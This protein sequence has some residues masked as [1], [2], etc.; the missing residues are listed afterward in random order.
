MDNLYASVAKVLELT[1]SKKSSLRTAVYNHK[2]KNKKQLLRLS[3]ETLKYRAYLTKIL[4]CQ[5]VMRHIIKCDKLNNQKEL[6]LILLYELV[7]GKGVSL[8]DK[9]IKR[10]VLGAKKDILTEHQALMDDGIDPES[11]AKT[12][13]IVLPRYGRVNTLKAGMDEV[14]SALQEEGYEFLDNSDVK[15]RTKFKKAVD[16]LQKYQFFVDRHVPEVLVF[17]PYVDLHN[18]L[19]FLESKLILQD[20]A[21]CLS[22]FVLKPDVGSVCVDACAAPGNKTSHLAALLEN[23]GEIWAYDKDKSRL[24]TLEERIGACGATIV[25]PTNSDFLRVPLEDLET[26]SYAIV[27]PPCSGSGMVRRGEFLAEEYNEKR[28]KGLS[29][30]QSMLL[31]HALKMP[32]LR[33]LVYSTCSIH[34]LENEGVIQEVLNEDWV[35]DTYELIDPLPS[36]KTRGKDGYDFSNLCIRADPKVDLTNGFFVVLFQRKNI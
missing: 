18:S 3:C 23:Q 7:F 30:L 2:F 20:K 13:S 26:V 1:V 28:I 14:I 36:W 22:A 8:G 5:D 16:N 6:C 10:A 11:I 34:E 27:D 32:N 4:E 25:I 31:K 24:G 19:L 29:N 21:S 35:K 17:S 12:E 33:R 9:Q 15:N